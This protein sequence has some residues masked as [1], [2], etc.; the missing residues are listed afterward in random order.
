MYCSELLRQVCLAERWD[1]DVRSFYSYLISLLC[2]VYWEEIKNIFSMKTFKNDNPQA[3]ICLWKNEMKISFCKY[4]G[5]G[6]GCLPSKP[7][8]CVRQSLGNS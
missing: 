3:T 6:G 2:D 5:E 7:L 1:S 8:A 4:A